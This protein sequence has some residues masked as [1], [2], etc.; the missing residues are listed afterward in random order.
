MPSVH[1]PLGS[2]TAKEVTDFVQI[3]R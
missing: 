2:I 1:H 3:Y